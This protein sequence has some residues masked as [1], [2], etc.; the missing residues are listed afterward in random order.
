MQIIVCGPKAHKNV[1]HNNSRKMGGKR[2]ELCG[3]SISEYL[4]VIK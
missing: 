1:I 4:T 2:T 3:S